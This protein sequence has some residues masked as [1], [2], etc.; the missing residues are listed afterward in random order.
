MGKIIQ[1]DIKKTFAKLHRKHLFFHATPQYCCA[2]IVLWLRFWPTMHCGNKQAFFCLKS[3]HI[4]TVSRCGAARP[5]AVLPASCC[6]GLMLAWS[7]ATDRWVGA[8]FLCLNSVFL[9]SISKT[10]HS[11]ALRFLGS[12]T[13]LVGWN[14]GYFSSSLNGFYFEWYPA[15]DL[16]CYQ[17]RKIRFEWQKHSIFYIKLVQ[18]YFLKVKVH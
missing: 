3:H 2:T 11:T 8:T 12:V 1:S 6:R 7:I 18:G 16:F 9:N 17:N 4:I 14:A 15:C 5:I 10:A 13:W